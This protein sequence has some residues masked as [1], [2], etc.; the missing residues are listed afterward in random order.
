MSKGVFKKSLIISC[1]GHLAAFGLFT[2]SF[3]N[4][5]PYL[6]PSNN[7]FWGTVLPRASLEETSSILTNKNNFFLFLGPQMIP[8]GNISKQDLIRKYYFKPSASLGVPSEKLM[9][10][11]VFKEPN[12]LQQNQK[13]PLLFY[14]ELPQH[15]LL[16]F[17]D[18]QAVHIELMFNILLGSKI[19]SIYIKRKVSSGNLEADLLT[20]R[21]ISRYLFIEQSR[22]PKNSW[23]TIKIDLSTKND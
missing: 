3:G 12:S 22:F 7:Y 8:K 13:Q 21:Y 10:A 16:F 14:P 17:K 2:F 20:M 5:L 15:F 19:N 23:Q 6:G 11:Y 9:G 4:K 18:R 1:L